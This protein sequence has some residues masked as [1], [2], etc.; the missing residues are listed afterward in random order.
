MRSWLLP[1]PGNE[2]T[3]MAAPK[4]RV[5]IIGGGNWAATAHIPALLNDQFK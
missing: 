2:V 1:M 4:V 5:I 3:K